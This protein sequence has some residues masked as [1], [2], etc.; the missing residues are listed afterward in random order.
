VNW[1]SAEEPYIKAKE[2]IEDAPEDVRQLIFETRSRN[3]FGKCGIKGCGQPLFD[4]IGCKEHAQHATPSQRL[5][6]RAERLGITKRHVR[7]YY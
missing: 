7:H 4:S 3:A 5:E 6:A 1:N 2:S